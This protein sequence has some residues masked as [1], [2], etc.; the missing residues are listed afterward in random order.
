MARADLERRTDGVLGGVHEVEHG[1]KNA[2][3]K[4]LEL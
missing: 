4:V 3:A 2:V 1:L